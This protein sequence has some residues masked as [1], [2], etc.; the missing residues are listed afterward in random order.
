MRRMF[1]KNQVK[2]I[3]KES[4]SEVVE[5]LK[6]QDIN[7]NG[8]TSKGIANTG[9]I[10]TT[11][12]IGA[13][14]KITGG[15]IVENMSG[16]SFTKSTN[17]NFAITYNYVGAV[18]NGNKLTL[19][20]SGIINF[21]AIPSSNLA[22]IGAF[23]IPSSIGSK[24]FPYNIG[25]LNDVVDNKKVSF[26]NTYS[27]YVDLPSVMFKNSDTEVELRLYNMPADMVNINYNFRYEVTFLLS[28]NLASE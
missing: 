14:G 5:A 28:E 1:S 7:V 25:S 17:P 8:I 12:D 24:I 4:S 16:Y 15:E 9:N 21:S 23:V 6:G 3:V 19:V 2:E 11:G 13:T 18:K 26:A 27:A 22:R 20:I 10:A